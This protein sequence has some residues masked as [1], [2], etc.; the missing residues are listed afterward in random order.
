MKKLPEKK[1]TGKILPG[2]ISHGEKI[3]QEIKSG[4]KFARKHCGEKMTRPKDS[5]SFLVCCCL[6][7]AFGSR[8]IV[9]CLRKEKI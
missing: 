2:N 3:D 8:D 4:K 5:L 7:I 9:L 1:F 6:F